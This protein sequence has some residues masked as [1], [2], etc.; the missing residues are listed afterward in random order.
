[1]VVDVETTQ[2]ETW[3]VQMHA[4]GLAIEYAEFIVDGKGHEVTATAGE[5]DGLLLT[6]PKP[7]SAKKF[8][9]KLKWSVPLGE[10][11]SSLYRVKSDGAWYAFTQF[12]PLEARAA[13]PSFDEPGLKTTY[14]VSLSTPKG[15]VAVANTPEK[16][17]VTPEAMENG[18]KE[19]EWTTHTFETSKP[20]PTYLVAFAVGPFDVVDAGEAAPGVPLRILA[21]KGK[22]NLTKYAAKVTP[23]IT[24]YLTEYF[25][26][27]F[28]Y[29]KL[30]MVAVPN[31]R[32]GAMENIGLVTYRESILL[33]EENA[34]VGAKARNQSI[35]A[36]ELAH[37]WFGNLVTL[38]WWGR[39]LA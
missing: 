31:F 25:G 18:P 12:E 30:D 14:D 6:S 4:R 38:A 21:P 22:G 34:G 15:L 35:I 24:K 7:V 17:N 39:P 29:K 37:M 19:G 20:M 1:M 11:A 10:K 9:V 16:P 23:G 8:Q 27:A 36:H 5:K 3:F 33:I 2:D 32:A 26:Q 13:F 28:P